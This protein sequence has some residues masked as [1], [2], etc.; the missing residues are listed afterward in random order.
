MH[1][2]T[3][4][5]SSRKEASRDAEGFR[6]AGGKV[7]QLELLELPCLHAASRVCLHTY[8]G[9]RS[10]RTNGC[11][12][13]TLASAMPT[14]PRE[15]VWKISCSLCRV[16]HLYIGANVL[17]RRSWASANCFTKT[18]IVP[19][20]PYDPASRLIASVLFRQSKKAGSRNRPQV[21]YCSST[22]K[23]SSSSWHTTGCHLDFHAVIRCHKRS[24]LHDPLR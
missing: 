11:I 6:R 12:L 23:I 9:L 5:E 8:Y 13:K 2:S 7:D 14:V 15:T 19:V 24:R 22:C 4:L 10:S 3:V 1:I 18:R 16:M 17:S 20:T 21:R